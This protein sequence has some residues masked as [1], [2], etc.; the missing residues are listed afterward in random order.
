MKPGICFPGSDRLLTRELLRRY[1]D[2]CRLFG[3]H[4]AEIEVKSCRVYDSGQTCLGAWR[5]KRFY[6][7]LYEEPNGSMRLSVNRTEIDLKTG[8]W[9]DGITW[10]ELNTV[11]E[12][13]GF[14]RVWAVEVFP[15]TPHLVNVA[16]IRHLFLLAGRPDYAWAKKKTKAENYAS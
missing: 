8:N 2:D 11:K 14:G 16:N 9:K 1:R 5:S 7:G 15:P 13:C 3:D 12:Q 4:M 6:A 10:D